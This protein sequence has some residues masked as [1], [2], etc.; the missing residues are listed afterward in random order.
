MV[1]THGT[2]PNGRRLLKPAARTQA[3]RGGVRQDGGAPIAGDPVH[4]GHLHRRAEIDSRY[5][6]EMRESGAVSASLGRFAPILS[7]QRQSAIT[8]VLVAAGAGACVGAA[9]AA[10][11]KLA[12]VVG[13][14]LLLMLYWALAKADARL[15]TVIAITSLALI[16]TYVAPTFRAFTPQPVA[17]IAIV[18]WLALYGRGKTGGTTRVDLAFGGLAA[19]MMIAGLVG[20]AGPFSTA[21]KLIVWGALFL[22]GRAVCRQQDGPFLFSVG[23]VAMGLATL[24]FLLLETFTGE[25]VFFSLASSSNSEASVWAQTDLRVGGLV[26]TEGAFGHPLTMTLALGGAAVFAFALALRARGAARLA[27]LA[28]AGCIAAGMASGHERSGWVVLV[29][30][31]LLLAAT[32]L[33]REG[34]LRYV[35]AIVLVVVPLGAVAIGL[36][37]NSSSG[38][39]AD[40][41]QESIEIRKDLYLHAL[42]PGAFETF[43]SR[44][45]RTYKRFANA[46]RP[47][48]QAIDAAYLEFGD[49][50]GWIVLLLALGSVGAVLS[51][52]VSS[53]GTW[54]AVVPS[55]AVATLVTITVIGLQTQVP[56]LV[57]LLAGGTSGVLLRGRSAAS[58]RGMSRLASS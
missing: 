3:C 13:A 58:S 50:Y 12:A 30:G 33:P 5:A 56:M 42:D 43:G 29:V 27:W 49:A 45:T 24:P 16:P 38:T 21:S 41:N 55:V 47:G 35:F 1:D 36:H 51:A 9:I 2:L 8:T 37:S 22:A 52:I 54:E 46:V 57:A 32:A 4:P 23:V 28:A 40:A 26:R 53:R 34:R 20:P 31:L 25:N 44:Q 15:A 10:D 39:A 14:G 6:R 18:L 19:G 48:T 11:A 7:D 17:A